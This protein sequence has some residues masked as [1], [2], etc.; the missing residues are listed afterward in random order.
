MTIKYFKLRIM[1][2]AWS[3]AIVL[4]FLVIWEVFVLSGK[5]NSF[6]FSSPSLILKDIVRM[7]QKGDILRHLGITVKQAGYGLFFGGLLGTMAAIM[8]GMNERLSNILFPIM[9]GLNGLPK[10]ALGPLLIIW[11]GIGIQSKIFMSALMV[12][13]PF[14]F[15]IHAGYHNVDLS[16]INTIKMMGGS[17]FQTL[18]KVIWP[19]CMPWLIV[20]IRTG[21]G[22]AIVGA[23]IGEYIGSS[24]GLGWMIMDAGGTYNTT[25]VLSCIFLLTVFMAAVDYIIKFFEKKMLRWRPSIN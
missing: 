2:F 7:Q 13:F 4:C 9:V 16:L 14:F 12:F 25:R 22:M 1:D 8:L 17:K 6:F 19:S 5:V 23:I 10:L 15:N 18:S 20:S 11:F 24:R 3:I 21:V